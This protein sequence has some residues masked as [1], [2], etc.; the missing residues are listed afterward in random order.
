MSDNQMR[1]K[2]MAPK[3]IVDTSGRFLYFLMVGMLPSL[4]IALNICGPNIIIV[5]TDDKKMMTSANDIQ[6]PA[7]SPIMF[8]NNKCPKMG[9]SVDALWA[10]TSGVRLDK[11]K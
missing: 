4:L 7:V 3:T 11:N 1:D 9:L 8:C 5:E 10:N 2:A 6:V